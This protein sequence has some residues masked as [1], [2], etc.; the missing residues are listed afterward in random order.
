[1]AERVAIERPRVAQKQ[2]AGRRSSRDMRDTPPAEDRLES[3]IAGEDLG[4]NRKS[5]SLCFP[6]FAVVKKRNGSRPQPIARAI[7]CKP[8]SLIARNPIFMCDANFPARRRLR[9][10]TTLCDDPVRLRNR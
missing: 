10:R 4:S 1:M 9:R 2:R 7:C 6:G 8:R 3:A 5:F